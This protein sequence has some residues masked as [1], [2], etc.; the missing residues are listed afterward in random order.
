MASSLDPC[1]LGAGPWLAACLLLLAGCA[2]NPHEATFKPSHSALADLPARAPPGQETHEA[3]DVL[4]RAIG[5]VGT[6]YHW[7]GNT[8]A[9]GFDCSGL[10]NYIY[11]QSTGLALPRT[12]SAMASMDRPKIRRQTALIS[13]DL[14]FFGRHGHISHVGVYVGKG[15]FVHAPNSGGTVR[16]DDI[17]GPYWR[18]HFAWGRRVLD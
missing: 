3:N 18:S 11:R 8:P 13:G 1:R 15:R 16:L 7:G 9:G 10:V 12:S 6:P 2:S 17:D 14:V 4:I 5:L